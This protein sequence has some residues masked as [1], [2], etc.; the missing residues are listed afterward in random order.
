MMPAVAQASLAC[1]VE[2]QV[3]MAQRE[4]ALVR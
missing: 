4:A 2:L 3:E 1:F